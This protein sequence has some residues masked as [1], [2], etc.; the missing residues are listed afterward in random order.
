[1]FFKKPVFTIIP[2]R[3]TACKKPRFILTSEFNHSGVI[4]I[5]LQKIL[6]EKRNRFISFSTLIARVPKNNSLTSR[7][8]KQTYEI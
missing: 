8:R 7:M 6:T 4:K 5:I 1:M 2:G 3:L